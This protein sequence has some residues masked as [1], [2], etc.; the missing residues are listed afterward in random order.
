M[1]LVILLINICL[2][3]SIFKNLKNKNM[4]L[5]PYTFFLILATTEFI[6]PLIYYLILEGESYKKFSN[7]ALLVYSM[8]VLFFY[9]TVAIQINLKKT[10][11][12]NMKR[13]VLK[14]S[15]EIYYKVFIFV[16]IFIVIIYIFINRNNLLLINL[17]KG[18]NEDLSRSD[19]TGLIKN[20][21][22]FS[23]IIILILPSFYFYYI[24]KIKSNML[25]FFLFLLVGIMTMIDGN[26]GLFIYLVLFLFIYIY[27]FKVNKNIVIYVLFAFFFYFLIK[28]SD[29]SA[30]MMTINSAIRRFFVTQGACFINRIQMIMDG[31]DFSNS[32]RVSSDV[33]LHMYGYSGGSAPTIFFGDILVNNGLIVMLISIIVSNN[34]FFRISNYLNDNYKDNHF[35]YWSY[36][37]IIYTLCMGEISS[38]HL[39]RVL[40]IL[41]FVFVYLML[42]ANNSLASRKE[43][44][45]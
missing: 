35:L 20:W 31:Y 34:L 11:R 26:K 15:K 38:D 28:G 10:F 45:E 2:A 1:L 9:I 43:R 33:F 17:L 32:I 3:I 23:T 5:T 6:G 24:D 44:I 30:I 14:G 27:R 8:I 25:S 7:N 36:A 29:V 37:S 21:Y 16:I 42:A 12:F 18:N 19:T 40:I 22:L 39:I 41:F 13:L 4:L